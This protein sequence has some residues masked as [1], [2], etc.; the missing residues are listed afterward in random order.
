MAVVR[1][2]VVPILFAGVAVAWTGSAEA[3]DEGAL[4]ELDR[5][6]QQLCERTSPS[7]VRVE[8][9]RTPSLRFVS[10]DAAE[11]ARFEDLMRSMR[12]REIVV[13]AGFVV[14]EA[15]LVATAADP[16]PAP[17]A[18]RVRFPRGPVREGTV[19]GTDPLSGVVLLRVDPVDGAAPLVLSKREAAP[20]RLS[21]LLAPEER[22]PACELRLGFVTEGRRAF[23]HYDAWLVS[24]VSVG[25]G[26][27]GAPL[28]DARG[29]VLGMA[30]AARE[31]P[32]PRQRMTAGGLPGAGGVAPASADPEDPYER[33]RLLS[34]LLIAAGDRRD[35]AAP[36]ATF[37][38]ASEMRRIVGELKSLGRVRRGMLGVR[39]LRP[40][41]VVGEVVAGTPAEA[42]GVGAGD[43]VVSLDGVAVDDT[44]VL[45][46][47]LQ[48]RAPGTRV[49]VA[50]R[51]P[52]GVERET[53]VVLAELPPVP[54]PPAAPAA[55]A[56]RQLF[57]GLSVQ[58]MPSY[59]TSAA[60]FSIGVPS[61]GSVSLVAS[62]VDE[63]SAAW[64][65]GIRPGDWIVE[66]D[67]RPLLS[68]KDFRDATTGSAALASSVRVLVYRAGEAE[69][70]AVVLK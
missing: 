17:S 2:A 70:R 46:A 18:I 19:V 40:E 25:A 8:V 26:Q 11:R 13:G 35:R 21:I 47:Y 34:Q 63:D 32:R 65:A 57:N 36:F 23:G 27:A 49:R 45:I 7:V 24:S 15:G 58:A 39:L 66:I 14:E 64:A 56:A 28:L 61:T 37:V 54:P 60:K 38:P 22:G 10:V 33:S 48:R 9:E 67:G 12:P 29:E 20:G 30:V 16:G 55:P 50:L 69:R 3:Q 53:E 6:A 44:E 42:A 62:E 52:G 59:D 31:R 5:A 68:E 41:P 43:R 51:D 4:V 1:G